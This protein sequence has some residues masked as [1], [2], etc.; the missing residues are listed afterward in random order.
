[1]YYQNILDSKIIRVTDWPQCHLVLPMHFPILSSCLHLLH[2]WDQLAE[3]QALTVSSHSQSRE[4]IIN[5]YPV[6]KIWQIL[7]NIESG[8]YFCHLNIC[9][10]CYLLFSFVEGSHITSLPGFS[11][12][13]NWSARFSETAHCPI[14]NIW[15][16]VSY[17]SHGFVF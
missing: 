17:L 13:S 9:M 1:M 6:T 11:E 10:K 12:Y 4:R 5:Y 7:S 15:Q 2:T 3:S 14:L 8:I 16:Y